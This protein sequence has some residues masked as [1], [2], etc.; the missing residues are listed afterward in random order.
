MGYATSGA[1]LFTFTGKQFQHSVNLYYLGYRYLDPKLGR[2]V[3]MDPLMDQKPSD[4]QAANRYAYARNN[5]LRFSDPDG[6]QWGIAT[7][8]VGGLLGFA[9]VAWVAPPVEVAILAV[10]AVIVVGYALYTLM[11]PKPTR[12]PIP[13]IPEVPFMPPSP[14]SEPSWRAPPEGQPSPPDSSINYDFGLDL[15]GRRELETEQHENE[16]DII[17]EH[18]NPTP[19]TKEMWAPP[20]VIFRNRY[21]YIC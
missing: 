20:E 4:P 15:G 16:V 14:T 11:T 7:G 10:V 12:P 8:I 21:Q 6:R 13:E 1:Q 9:G 3:Q 19:D 17:L 18:N 5:P 2:F